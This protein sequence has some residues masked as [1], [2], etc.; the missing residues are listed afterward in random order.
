MGLQYH[1]VNEEYM[2]AEQKSVEGQQNQGGK[3]EWRELVFLKFEKG[4]NTIRILPPWSGEGWDA[5]RFNHKVLTWM[6]VPPN[7]K[8]VVNVR[9]TFPDLGLE[10]P[11][12]EVVNDLRARG[13]NPSIEMWRQILVNAILRGPKG[14]W[15][16][17]P[18][19]GLPMNQICRLPMSVYNW[20]L[21]EVMSPGG[22]GFEVFD[23]IKGVDVKINFDPSKDSQGRYSAKFDSAPSPLHED[24]ETMEWLL[25]SDKDLDYGMYDL[26]GIL[27]WGPPNETRMR[28][29]TEIAT[30]YR[31]SVLGSGRRVQ[32][33]PTSGQGGRQGAQGGQGGH[34]R[35][36]S[37]Q[38]GQGGQNRPT[39]G[40]GG[41][42]GAQGGQ[43]GQGGQG[44]QGAQGGQGGQG[45][46]NGQGGQSLQKNLSQ[47]GRPECYGNRVDG[48]NKC[49]VCPFE[50][51]C[52]G[53]TQERIGKG[54][55]IRK[56]WPDD[57]DPK[58]PDSVQVIDNNVPF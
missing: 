52:L 55:P 4:Q 26:G 40:Q 6:H 1:A 27:D 46:Q 28:E 16:E 29:Y 30:A 15:V 49:V 8:N 17:G 57:F 53:Y 45:A 47:D 11:V 34:T 51:K 21:T 39:S 18:N 31:V 24:Y 7:G 38:G 12:E 44:A 54:L 10:C 56:H 50:I 41:R 36:T 25:K 20:F 42:Q 19:K 2:R 22:I 32:P 48:F 13:M 37:G 43:G 5:G 33:R 14:M 9:E 23:P 35:P 58:L 3:K